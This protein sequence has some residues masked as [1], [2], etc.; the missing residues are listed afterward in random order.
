MMDLETRL[1]ESL[2]A[3]ADLAADVDLPDPARFRSAAPTPDVVPVRR[4]RRDVFLTAAAAGLV[5]AAVAAFL[6]SATDQKVEISPAVTPVA[7][8][9]AFTADWYP[10]DLG[11]QPEQGGFDD[12]SRVHGTYGYTV[13]GRD[14]RAEVAVRVT[15]ALMDFSRRMYGSDSSK[16]TVGGEAAQSYRSSGVEF[17]SIDRRPGLSVVLSGRNADRATLEALSAAFPGSL[18]E[19][20]AAQLPAG[21]AEVDDPGRITSL[22]MMASLSVRSG[23][24]TLLPQGTPS[25]RALSVGWASIDDP[26]GAIDRMEQLW[27]GEP[28]RV[29]DRDGVI[30][31][32]A[33]G[34]PTDREILVVPFDDHHLGWVFPND[35]DRAETVR[36]AASIRRASPAEWARLAS[37][38]PTTT[39][40]GFVLQGASAEVLARGKDGDREWMLASIESPDPQTLRRGQLVFRHPDGAQSSMETPLGQLVDPSVSSDGRLVTEIAFVPNGVTDVRIESEGAPLD[41]VAAPIAG[42][43]SQIVFATQAAIDVDEMWPSHRLTV[44]GTNPDGTPYTPPPAGSGMSFA[45]GSTT[46]TPG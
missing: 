43:D 28:V 6:T 15:T 1:R 24:F 8:D 25:S 31:T 14:G 5:I 34:S 3:R 30:V 42:M 33:F 46:T 44:T 18:G 39:I 17:L 20:D 21:W 40:D 37:P 29:G 38:R 10:A 36:L 9:V 22:P 16:T 11:P 35:V 27:G 2:T 32:S 26:T 4:R 41:T 45:L 7:D 12:P 19:F 13:L 23:S